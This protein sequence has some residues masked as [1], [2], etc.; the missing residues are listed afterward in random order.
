MKTTYKQTRFWN[1]LEKLRFDGVGKYGIPEIKPQQYDGLED[2][3]WIGFNYASTCRTRS[4]KGVHFYLD[5]YQFDRIWFDINRYC[6]LLGEYKVSLTPDWSIY[7]DWP[8]AVNI[9]NHYKKHYFGAYLQHYGFT[10]IPSVNWGGKETFDWCF[11]GEPIN[12]CVAVS[13]V[14][15]QMGQES[16]SGFVYGW[17]AMI[18]RLNPSTILFWGAVPNECKGN[19]IKM[20]EFQKR[21]KNKGNSSGE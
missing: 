21:L 7:R 6:A 17:N 4:W 2:V 20:D 19:I 5:D 3:E 9:F 16:K 15:T 11:D 1:N 14:G 18:E 12:S 8:D 10:V 13:S